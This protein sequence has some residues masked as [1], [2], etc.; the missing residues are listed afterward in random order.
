[1][2]LA[3]AQITV[4]LLRAPVQRAMRTA[5][6]VLHSRPS[7]LIRLE[8]RD[9][10]VGW[11]E[12]YCNNPPGAGEHRA[13]LLRAVFLPLIAGHDFA[14][15]AA[16]YHHLTQRTRV[17]ALQCGE[18]G[19]FAQCI[20]GIDIAAWDLVARRAGQTLRVALGGADTP[21]IPAYLSGLDP[22]GPERLAQAGWDQGHRAFKLKLGFGRALDLRNAEAMRSALGP[23]VPIAMDANQVWNEAET[24]EM[25]ARLA[26]F[27][28]EW[29]E[30][31]LPADTPLPVW[32]SLAA[33]CPLPLAAGENLRGAAAFD[34][35]I[36]SGAFAVLQPDPVKWGGLTAL[37]PLARSIGAAGLRFCPHYLGGGLGLVAAAQLAAAAGGPGTM[38]ELDENENPLRTLLATPFPAIRDG[39]MLLPDTPGLGVVPD[40]VACRPYSV[41]EWSERLE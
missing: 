41:V 35:A 39:H 24:L 9:G 27:A 38:L 16:L 10:A 6:G 3:L 34:E 19:P 20:A 1:M 25:A 33:A 5:F 32:R 7:L 26:P 13:T 28:P 4:H 8:G 11:G 15:P 30:E 37:A 22:D 14:D 2:S 23:G 12:A 18:P 21:S 31:P 17:L 36:A 40:L 29:L